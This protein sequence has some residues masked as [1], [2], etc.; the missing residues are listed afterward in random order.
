MKLITADFLNYDLGFRNNLPYFILRL[1][2]EC[3]GDIKSDIEWGSIWNPGFIGF[4]DLHGT[5]PQRGLT[6]Q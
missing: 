6:S 2:I 4:L 3:G 1:K 5:K